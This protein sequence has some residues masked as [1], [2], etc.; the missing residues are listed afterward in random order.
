MNKTELKTE[1]DV[2]LAQLTRH[3]FNESQGI[4]TGVVGVTAGVGLVISG[5]AI[6]PA[7]AVAVATVATVVCA[8]AVLAE[9]NDYKRRKSV[10]SEKQLDE[11]WVLMTAHV[12]EENA[13]ARWDKIME[14][15]R[16]DN[17]YSRNVAQ[18]VVDKNNVV[19]RKESFTLF[20]DAID[21]VKRHIDQSGG[22]V[23]PLHVAKMIELR[24]IVE[25]RQYIE[26]DR[27]QGFGGTWRGYFKDAV[28]TWRINNGLNTVS[29]KGSQTS[30]EYFIETI[31]SFLTAHYATVAKKS[32]DDAMELPISDK[33]TD[34]LA[35]IK[36]IQSAAL[37]DKH[38]RKY[39]PGE[40]SGEVG[41]AANF[42]FKARLVG[43]LEGMK[44]AGMQSIDSMHPAEEASRGELAV[45]FVEAT[46]KA[47]E[48]I[49]DYDRYLPNQ[50]TTDSVE[51][52]WVE[53]E[54]TNK[55]ELTHSEATEGVYAF[56]DKMKEYVYIHG[57][58]SAAIKYSE[59]FYISMEEILNS[60]LYRDEPLEAPGKYNLSG[61][62]RVRLERVFERIQE[63]APQL[64]TVEIEKLQAVKIDAGNCMN[65][66]EI[67]ERVVDAGIVQKAATPFM[68][69]DIVAKN[70]Q[71]IENS[72]KTLRASISLG[73]D[74]S[75]WNSEERML[76]AVGIAAELRRAM[77]LA[78][79]SLKTC[80]ETRDL[81][82]DWCKYG[83]IGRDF[84]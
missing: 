66:M 78:E 44:K 4:K 37:I 48:R 33:P 35:V 2:R 20:Q 5:T 83:E 75:T 63:H 27:G 54:K 8:S 7:V 68:T 70:L 15:R 51:I 40:R 57:V 22:R 76:P 1:R 55:E 39:L 17:P 73:L 26:D 45:A 19:H 61:G 18:D 65:F 25:H 52:A 23:E 30:N 41:E 80:I 74:D 16:D 53:F 14:N 59:A 84:F 24:D 12:S 81:T 3:F 42:V 21:A 11:D 60:K 71:V 29:L 69:D 79:K 34:L 64:A 36:K 38:I 67:A 6:L 13:Q 9:W 72:V 49:K 10:V 82:H 28:D 50:F 58:T 56:H 62:I 32:L 77:D 31:D 46:Q 47:A 43:Q